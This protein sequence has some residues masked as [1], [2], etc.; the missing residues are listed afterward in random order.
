MKLYSYQWQ[1][2]ALN[3]VGDWHP[4]PKAY[5]TLVRAEGAALRWRANMAAE[6]C[7]VACRV[8]ELVP[9]GTGRRSEVRFTVQ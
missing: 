3:G 5:K 7:A 2:A 9:E 6:N 8:V 4:S 1:V